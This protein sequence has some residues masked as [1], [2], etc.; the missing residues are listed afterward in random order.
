MRALADAEARYKQTLAN[1]RAA[2]ERALAVVAIR[3]A[4][5]SA[6]DDVVPAEVPQAMEVQQVAAHRILE[7]DTARRAA[8]FDALATSLPAAP[9]KTFMVVNLL[10]A[11]PEAAAELSAAASANI[12]VVGYAADAHG[13]SRIIGALRCFTDP[14]TADEAV[15]AVEGARPGVPRRVLTLSDDIDAFLPAKAGLSRAGHSVS[16]ACDAKQA[17]DLLTILCPDAVLV[18]FRTAPHAA[19]QILSL[20]TQE[21]GNTQV[22]LV[23]GDPENE[24]LSQMMRRLLRPAPLDPADLVRVCCATLNGPA[25]AARTVQMKPIVFERP[26]P[27]VRKPAPRRLGTRRR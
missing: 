18:D 20:I 11:L 15:A 1:T 19:A 22:L 14:P 26:R 5:G 10:T 27:P 13:Q 7:P 23:H 21:Q 17:S 16:M 12:T 6:L 2:H 9:G 4:E 24:A 8:I 3:T 25:A